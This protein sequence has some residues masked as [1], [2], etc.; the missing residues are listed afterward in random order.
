MKT[1]WDYTERE[2]SEMTEDQVTALLDVELMSKG[3]LKVVAPILNK[4]E[5]VDLPTETKYE[6][7]GILFVTVEQAQAFLALKLGKA[8]TPEQINEANVWFAPADGPSS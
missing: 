3:V 2:R 6:A 4:I 7:G 5:P 1:Y 8:F